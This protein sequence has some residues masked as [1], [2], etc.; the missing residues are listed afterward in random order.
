M[1]NR[2]RRGLRPAAAFSIFVLVPFCNHSGGAEMA[3]L[4]IKGV[5]GELLDRLRKRAELHRRSLNSEALV[6]LEQGVGPKRIDPR[7]FIA[8]L[9]RR[10]AQ[11][12]D[13]TPLTDEFLEEAI[14]EGRP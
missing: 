8:R 4:T 13:I 10:H 7:E 14:N 1:V 11:M 3:S 5:P 6:L 12:K 2:S 9:D